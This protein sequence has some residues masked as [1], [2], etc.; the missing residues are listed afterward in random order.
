MPFQHMSDLRVSLLREVDLHSND[1]QC[2]YSINCVLKVERGFITV[3][4]LQCL[5]NQIPLLNHVRIRYLRF[6]AGG[7]PLYC[8]IGVAYLIINA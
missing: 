5:W 7:L 4:R 8:V 6:T 1:S 3:L 2:S